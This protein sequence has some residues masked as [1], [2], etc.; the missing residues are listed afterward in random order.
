[1]I[2]FNFNLLFADCHTIGGDRHDVITVLGIP[3]HTII[4]S[5]IPLYERD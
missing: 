1:M 3:G 2:C 5:T 4:F